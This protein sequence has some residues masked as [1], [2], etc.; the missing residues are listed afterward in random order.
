MRSLR[1]PVPVLSPGRAGALV[2][3][4]LVFGHALVARAQPAAPPAVTTS[5][6]GD[7]RGFPRGTWELRPVM[8]MNGTVAGMPMPRPNQQNPA[9]ETSLQLGLDAY[10]SL[11]GGTQLLAGAWGATGEGFIGAQAHLGVKHRFFG[12]NPAVIPTV[13]GGLGFQWGLPRTGTD[14]RTV[15][16]LGLRVGVGLDFQA[17]PR[18]YPGIQVVMD[19]GPRLL[20]EVGILA[21]T[22]VTVGVGFIL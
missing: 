17:T 2:V 14:R 12:A 22:Q 13:L 18:V 15:T 10:Y 9:Y 3:A 8:G 6:A 11:G 21:T 4:A 16:G 20:P 7:A 1:V 19:L 5:P